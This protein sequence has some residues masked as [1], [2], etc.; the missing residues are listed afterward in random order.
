MKPGRWDA[1]LALRDVAIA[2]P[3]IS[4][5][6]LPLLTENSFQTTPLP[7]YL[8]LSVYWY[9]GYLS[10]PPLS[11]SPSYYLELE[12]VKSYD[13]HGW[14]FLWFIGQLWSYMVCLSRSYHIKFFK[15]YLP[16]ILFGSFLNT[17]T[18]F[19]NEVFAQPE[20]AVSH[21]KIVTYFL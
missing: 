13:K 21:Q 11:L 3:I 15:G 1:S 2:V 17:L 8:D 20:K 12:S 16:Q 18:H 14:Y 4:G 10:D 7:F 9:L 19:F 5:N 6:E